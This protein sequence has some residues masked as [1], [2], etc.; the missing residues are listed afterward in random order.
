M[1]KEV[2]I[3]PQVFDNE[4][5]DLS[6]WKDIKNL[7]DA[8]TE[9]G[10]IVSLNSKDWTKTVLENIR[11]L[12]PKIKDRLFNV[13][14][15]LKDRDRIVRHP[16][17]QDIMLDS[18]D[19]WYKL[20]ESLDVLRHFYK[21]IT[22]KA[23]NNEVLTLEELED[24]NISQEFGMPGSQHYVK[25]IENL[26]KILLP[27]L[28]YSKK[29]TIIDPYFYLS[30]SRYEE[31]LTV[32]AKCFMERRGELGKGSIIINCKYDDQKHT[33]YVLNQWQKVLVRMTEQFPHTFTI[34]A[35]CVRD[36][37]LKMHDRYFI[38][39]QSGLVSAAGADKDDK[40]Q[41]EWSLKTHRDLD[42]ILSQYKVNSSPFD[43]KRI[44]TTTN[45]D[46]F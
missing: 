42:A 1:L 24:L 15:T 5:L 23:Y 37:E 14:S 9:S 8:I 29:L 7:L 27:F 10:Y 35:W 33:D 38:T 21:I 22:T 43:L 20:A 3:T 39:N 31:T 17:S 32:V 46:K 44:I 34:N 25:S 11:V 13:I 36:G 26:N 6:N 45:I 41:S 18:E 40:Q 4:H 16:K 12:E 19:S 30:S 2:C 28:S